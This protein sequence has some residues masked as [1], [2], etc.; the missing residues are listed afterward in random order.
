M[1]ARQRPD[2][3]QLKKTVSS[4]DQEACKKTS[5]NPKLRSQIR[6]KMET[7]PRTCWH[8]LIEKNI[9]EGLENPEH[10]TPR[11]HSACIRGSIAEGAQRKAGRVQTAALD[12]RHCSAGSSTT[13]P[14][15][16]HQDPAIVLASCWPGETEPFPGPHSWSFP[17]GPE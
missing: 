17:H 9:R 4:G 15:H 12:L 8:Q 7:A 14:H 5:A 1:A 3:G 6:E 16:L 11:L 13:S 10:S 2:P